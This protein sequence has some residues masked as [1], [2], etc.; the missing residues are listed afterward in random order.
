[1][2]WVRLNA[3]ATLTRDEYTTPA[4]IR[5]IAL[6]FEVGGL[7]AMKAGPFPEKIDAELSGIIMEI[8]D[9]RRVPCVPDRP[10]Q[11]RRQL[12]NRALCR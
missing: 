10:E 8:N 3:P 5:K 11:D 6:F 4:A 2:D 1:L 7:A 9:L 12:C